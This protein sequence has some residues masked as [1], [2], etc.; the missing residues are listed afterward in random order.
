MN[1][2]LRIRCAQKRLHKKIDQAAQF[3]KWRVMEAAAIA[4]GAVHEAFEHQARSLGAHRR[5]RNVRGNH[6]A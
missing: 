2:D 3:A 5:W 4:Q 6:G 1:L